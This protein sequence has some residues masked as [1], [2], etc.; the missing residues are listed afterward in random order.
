MVTVRQGTVYVPVVNIGDTM[1]YLHPHCPLGVLSQAQIVSLPKGFSTVIQ[2]PSTVT[3]RFSSH[4]ALG[5]SVREQIRSLYLSFPP[6]LEQDKVGAMLSERE[7]V[8]AASDSDLGHTSLV[9]HDILLLD[10]VP[11]RQRYRCMPPSNY[12]DVRARICQLLES[13]VIREWQPVCLS[14]RPSS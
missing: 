7:A 13:T 6:S 2:Q 8:F 12:D 3:A 9:T 11:M 1:V 5:S 14:H 4:D 10:D